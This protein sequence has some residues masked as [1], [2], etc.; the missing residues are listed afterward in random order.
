M[1]FSEKL[2]NLEEKSYKKFKYSVFQE[3]G[4]AEIIKKWRR[5]RNV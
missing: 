3:K 2:K 1:S 4:Q 5:R